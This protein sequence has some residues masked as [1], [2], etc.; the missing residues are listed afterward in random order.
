MSICLE[1]EDLPPEVKKAVDLAETKQ[2]SL[3]LKW[4]GGSVG[5]PEGS[6]VKIFLGFIGIPVKFDVPAMKTRPY[7]T[8][9]LVLTIIGVNVAVWILHYGLQA[10]YGFGLIPGAMFRKCGI[11]FFSSFFV[12]GGILHLIGNMYFLLAFGD[13]VEDRLGHFKYLLLIIAATL[14]G[15][16]LH[17]IFN[18]GSEIPM[19]GASGGISGVMAFYA[20][21]Y[22]RSR[23]GFMFFSRWSMFVDHWL[24]FP[25]WLM[26]VV[27][28][29]FQFVGLHGYSRVA[30]FAHLGGAL[31]GIL[32]WLGL[33]LTA[34]KDEYRNGGGDY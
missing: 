6:L 5:G 12:H 10:I 33:K 1:Q 2:K 20:L 7:A 24:K 3:E 17:I 30:Y 8:W 31:A 9:G 18:L 29:I 25:V 14:I 15:D 34:K 23:I 16:F 28:V 22:P 11:T 32:F 4:N 13:S 21:Q 26:F 27:W 19:V